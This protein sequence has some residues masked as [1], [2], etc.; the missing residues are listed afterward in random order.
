M[1]MRELYQ[2][3]CD[4]CPNI[5]E[6]ISTEEKKANL[7]AQY[8]GWRWILKSEGGK[9][10]AKD[11]CTECVSKYRGPHKLRLYDDSKRGQAN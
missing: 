4:S 1:G 7:M 6:M 2:V 5:C 8:L 11:L 3:T 9:P 10:D